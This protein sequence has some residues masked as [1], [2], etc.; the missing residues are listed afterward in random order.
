LR[1]YPSSGIYNAPVVL[2]AVQRA[3]ADF[4][5]EESF[6]QASLRFQEHWEAP[7]ST[8]L[9]KVIFFH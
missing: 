7:A 3:L 8:Q 9:L 6:G 1:Y 2:I 4:A 5:A